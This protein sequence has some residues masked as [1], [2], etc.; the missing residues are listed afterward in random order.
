M[1]PPR[2]A[3]CGSRPGCGHDDGAEKMMSNLQELI[4]LMK[5]LEDQ[6]VVCMRCGMCQAVCPVYAQTGREADVA[7]GKLAL[8][9][10]LMKSMLDDPGSVQERLNR[11]LLCGSC[12]ANCPSGVRVLEIFLKARAIITGYTGLSPAKQLLLRGMLSHPATFDRLA[13]WAAR[14]QKLFIRPVNEVAGTSCARLVSPLLSKRHFNPLAAHPFH[15]RTPSVQTQ[16]GSSGIKAAFFV[17]CLIDKIFPNLAQAALD[18]LD[19]HGVGVFLPQG[20]G[21]CGIPAL[22]SGDLQTFERLLRH[23]VDQFSDGEADYLVTACATC[24]STI[25]EI[26]PAMVAS[27][28]ETLRQQVGELASRTVDIHQLL[29]DKVGVKNTGTD[30]TVSQTVVTYHD[31]CHLKKSLGVTSQPRELIRHASG[32]RLVEMAESDAC[33]GMG[34][35]FNLQHYELSS[36]IGRLKQENI[37]ATECAIVATGCPA[38]MLQISEALSK[39]GERIAVK[40]PVEIYADAINRK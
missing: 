34:G 40:H 16:A 15:L 25:K 28:N 6:L 20:Q 1:Q 18:V 11:C 8:L 23:S 37:R 38:C 30:K 29:V 24:T 3:Q 26:W 17:G 32:Y 33:C 5:D 14:F 31:P 9:D 22:S 21:C 39:A 10:G 13:Q 12:A 36:R 7:R 2:H 19:Y 35:S 27:E 4:R